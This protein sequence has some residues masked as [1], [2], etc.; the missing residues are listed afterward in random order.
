M[1][2]NSFPDNTRALIEKP[3]F[4][5]DLTGFENLKLLASIQNKIDDKKIKDT[6][7]KVNLSEESDKKYA[8][9]S[10]GTKQKLGIAQ[11]LMEDPNIIILDEPFNGVENE[12]ADNIRKILREERDKGKIII[13]ASHI[14]EDIYGLADVVYEVDAGKI[15]KKNNL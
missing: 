2:N 4:L 11:V 15:T 8:K 1:K 3:N 5:P 9:Y 10:L 12:T 7:S 14:K 6:L 13:L